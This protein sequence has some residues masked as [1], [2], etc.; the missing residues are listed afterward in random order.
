MTP[1][2]A[3][4]Y[5]LRCAELC[6][7]SH[8]AILAPVRVLDEAGYRDWIESALAAQSNPVLAGEILYS[9]KGCSGC[10]SIDGSRVVGPSWQGL[11]GSERNFVDGSSTIADENYIRNSILNPNGLVTEGYPANVMPQNYAQ[12]LSAVEI[13]QL[14]AYIKSLSET[15]IE[16]LQAEGVLDAEGNPIEDN[17]SGDG[18]NTTQEV[19]TTAEN[20]GSGDSMNTDGGE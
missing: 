4:D 10:H 18:Q 15:G 20:A 1:N 16:E 13:D 14:I 11:Y 7:T 17:N 19:G 3:G 5:K 8:W 9:A 12:E 6:G 2:L